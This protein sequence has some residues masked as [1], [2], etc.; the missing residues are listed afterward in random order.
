MF[1]RREWDLCAFV[2]V[3]NRKRRINNKPMMNDYGRKGIFC[4][5]GEKNIFWV[6]DFWSSINISFAGNITAVF[7]TRKKGEEMAELLNRDHQLNVSIIEGSKCTKQLGNINR[8]VGVIGRTHGSNA[9]E[10]YIRICRTCR[11]NYL[12]R[13]L[14]RGDPWMR[15]IWRGVHKS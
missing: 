4:C 11:I 3:I 6:T 2:W 8:W 7:T 1:I 13:I 10:K 15:I 14:C 5:F 9:L 12:N